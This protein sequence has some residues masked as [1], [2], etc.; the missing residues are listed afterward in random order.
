MEWNFEGYIDR[1]GMPVF[2]TPNDAVVGVDGEDIYHG[3]ISYWN[4]EVDSLG[5]DPDA[6]NEF[7]RQFPRS[8]SHA[9]RDESKASIFNLTKIYQ[10]I[11]YN[12]SLITAHHLTRGSFSWQNGIK[13]S[14]VVW[15]P[16]K[17]G[18]FLVSWT[19]PPHLQ[20]RVDIRNGVRHPGNDHLGC[21]GCDSYD[22]S[23]VVVGKGSN[24]ALHGLTK[25]NMDDAPSNEFFLEYI[26]R[27]QTAEIF[28]EEVLMA[29]VF[30]GMPILAENNKPRLLYH[31]KNRG[32]RG[33]SINRPDKAY[34]KLSKTEKELGGIPNSSEDVKQAHAAAIE[35][36][37]EKHIGIDMSGSFRESDDMGTMYFTNTLEDW[38]KFDINNRTKYDAAISSGLAIMANQK[39]LYTPTKQKSKISINFARY[40]NNSSVSQ[41]IK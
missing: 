19:P 25:F 23:G 15:S 4:N 7:Y 18:R 30:Y 34:N 38:A 39:H 27:P 6:L 40:N 17:S 11:D 26:A 13:D 35:S 8:E 28:F 36:Y 2:H 22:I 14:K 41:L 33:F 9:F 24:G 31:L 1:Y 5:S 32:Y 21:F 3:A 12:D 29:C 37:I 16:N 20:N 10:Q